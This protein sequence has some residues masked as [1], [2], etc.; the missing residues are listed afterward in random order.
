MLWATLLFASV[1]L[2]EEE[3]ELMI[4]S[5]TS[6]ADYCILLCRVPGKFPP[7]SHTYEVVK[8]CLEEAENVSLN[9]IR[10]S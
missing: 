8:I 9:P 5:K 7:F 1:T 2:Q 6:R 3:A 4:T 10:L